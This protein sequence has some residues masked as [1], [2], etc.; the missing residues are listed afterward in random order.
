MCVMFNVSFSGNA[1]FSN[2]L[3]QGIKN[4]I[5]FS[6][7]LEYQIHYLFLNLLINI[8]GLRMWDDFDSQVHQSVPS[9]E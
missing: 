2:E 5:S 3:M 1:V 7:V 4:Q 8:I 6:F 9:L